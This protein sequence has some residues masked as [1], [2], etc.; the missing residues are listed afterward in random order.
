[1]SRDLD[2]TG[3]VE[4]KHGE[5]SSCAVNPTT[6]NLAVSDNSFAGD[7][8][9]IYAHARGYGKVIKNP[10]QRQYV[11]L[12]YDRSGTLW[13]DGYDGAGNFILSSCGASSCRTIPITGG[14]VNH[15]G[16][17]QWAAGQRS[18]YV[19]DAACGYDFE[20]ICIYPVSARGALGAPIWPRAPTGQNIFGGCLEQGAITDGQS[21][22][23]AAGVRDTYCGSITGA[24]R[25]NFPAGGLPTQDNDADLVQ[26]YGAAISE[27]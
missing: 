6:G 22:V 10:Q 26:P 2:E 1:M 17:V 20:Y 4:D 13:V 14:K 11:W 3:Q 16:F 19:A 7:N 9:V 5:P 27:K 12:G 18:W 21:R 23:L 15:A 24:A 25:W 8:L